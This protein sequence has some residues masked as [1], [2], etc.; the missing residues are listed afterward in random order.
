MTAVT[1]TQAPTQEVPVAELWPA[2]GYRL[3]RVDLLPPE[4]RAARHLRRV[5]QGLGAG[6]VVV[7]LLV[8][9]ATALAESSASTARDELAAAQARTAALQA[10]QAQYAEVTQVLSQLEEVESARARAMAGDV[11][12]ASYLDE[13]SGRAPAGVWLQQL[14]VALQPTAVAGGVP[15]EAADPL[16]DPAIATITV[17]G[18]GGSY[19]DVAAWLDG[20]T[21]VPGLSDARYSIATRA[22]TEERPVV[23]FSSTVGVVPD[24]LSHR[25]D[26]EDG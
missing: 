14:G 10:E 8:S 11:L 13:I 22:G 3:P 15:A 16:A 6:V 24:A 9:G 1:P 7:L 21:A 2:S 26:R 5:Q 20:L 12:W 4:I 18:S 23:E 19:E 17:V 25:H